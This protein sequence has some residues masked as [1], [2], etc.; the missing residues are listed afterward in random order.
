MYRYYKNTGAGDQRRSQ[1]GRLRG[2]H[3]RH[4][5]GL[6]RAGHDG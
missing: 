1:A 2:R 3:L 6:P 5:P 4:L